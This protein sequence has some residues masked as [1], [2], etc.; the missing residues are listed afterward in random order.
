M[1]ETMIVDAATKL[2]AAAVLGILL[3]VVIIR[4][5]SA[6]VAAQDRVAAAVDHQVAAITALTA[7]IT[8]VEAK[9][10]H[11]LAI[12]RDRDRDRTPT[13]VEIPVTQRAAAGAVGPTTYVL[14]GPGG[15][16]G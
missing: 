1:T 16:E 4:V 5:G 8:R 15:K 9:L 13:P 11:Q 10:D 14:P 7:A 6:L 2:G 3:Y 12:D